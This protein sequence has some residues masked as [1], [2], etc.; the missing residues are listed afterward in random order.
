MATLRRIASLLDPVYSGKAFAG[1]I[2]DVRSG[3]YPAGSS[4]VFLMTVGSPALFAYR[5]SFTRQGA[6]P[7]HS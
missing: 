7:S 2:R 6:G 1:L 4:I 5:A 3:R